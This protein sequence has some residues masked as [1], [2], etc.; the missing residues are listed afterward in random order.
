MA[1]VKFFNEEAINASNAEAAAV[2]LDLAKLS[3][4]GEKSEQERVC[5]SILKHGSNYEKSFRLAST[6]I[7]A[8]DL[9]TITVLSLAAENIAHQRNETKV[10]DIPYSYCGISQGLLMTGLGVSGVHCQGRNCY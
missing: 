4:F 1:L 5:V 9:V 7:A 10:K 8:F 2:H 3:L 6:I